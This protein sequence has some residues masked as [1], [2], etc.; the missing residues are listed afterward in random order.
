M[1]QERE[2]RG[3]PISSWPFVIFADSVFPSV[4][5]FLPHAIHLF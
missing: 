1:R 2:M 4:F 5:P 3:A